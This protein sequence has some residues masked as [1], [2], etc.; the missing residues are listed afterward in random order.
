MPTDAPAA[1]GVLEL[2]QLFAFEEIAWLREA[3]IAIAQREGAGRNGHSRDVH[4]VHHGE[5]GFR[6]LAAHPRLL[7]R[8]RQ[9]AAGPVTLRAT[10]LS[11]GPGFEVGADASE[12]VRA[13]VFLDTGVGS[14]LGSA[15]LL[16]GT[17]AYRDARPAAG[18]LAFVATFAWAD[19]RPEWIDAALR[20]EPDDCLY[21]T[22]FLA[23]G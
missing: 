23:A 11:V 8:V 9:V 2:P 16:D 21:Q 4:D 1:D 20:N 5:A 13:V 10:R 3:A 12:A 19:A 17:A 22:P 14:R 18:T 6:K 15:L 7:E